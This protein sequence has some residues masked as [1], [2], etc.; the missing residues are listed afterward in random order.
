MIF[1]PK[2]YFESVKDITIDFLKQNN[3]NA[4]IL[5]VDNTIIDYDKNIAPGVK[6][7][8]D[9]LKGQGIKFCILSNTNKIE[10][11]KKAAEALQL[12]YFYFAKKPSK[13]G[14]RKAIALLNENAENIA[15]VGDQIFTDVLGANRC[16]LYPILVKP[17][18][19]RDIF[20]TKL[21]R[22]IENIVIKRYLE[23]IREE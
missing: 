16:N 17:V 22:P 15:A 23:S 19:K 4:L 1:Y 13:G 7:W 6:E 5:D 12:P 14:F 11:V 8:C 2:V 10:K 20:T 21:K 3:I 18:D 9:D